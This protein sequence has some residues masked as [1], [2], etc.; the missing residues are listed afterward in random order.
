MYELPNDWLNFWLT[1]R[2][3]LIFRYVG[4]GVFCRETFYDQ[5][6]ADRQAKGCTTTLGHLA[7][8]KAQSTVSTS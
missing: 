2:S 8:I 3:I 5:F 1:L 4:V 6:Y 7:L